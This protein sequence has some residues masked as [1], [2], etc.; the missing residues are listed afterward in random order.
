MTAAKD[1]AWAAWHAAEQQAK[2]EMSATHGRLRG[3]AKAAREAGAFFDDD[4]NYSP[5][6]AFVSAFS[7]TVTEYLV[8]ENGEW[9]TPAA[10]T[11]PSASKLFEWAFLIAK[12]E[13]TFWTIAGSRE[14]EANAR[15]EAIEKIFGLTHVSAGTRSALQ[16]AA[17][18]KLD[19]HYGD[20]GKWKASWTAGNRYPKFMAVTT[21]EEYLGS[22]IV[23]D[24][25]SLAPRSPTAEA[26]QAESPEDEEQ[27]LWP[28][29]Y[30]S[31]TSWR[32]RGRP[33]TGEIGKF[34]AANRFLAAMG[35]GA[36]SAAALEHTWVTRK[37]NGR[38]S[39]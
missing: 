8:D 38:D 9:P 24:I 2:E 26:G 23:H 14:A 22:C 10:A 4:V 36:A 5:F 11:V 12:T 15:Y 21:F 16:V 39:D 34:E 13:L 33:P 25:R 30:Q 7:E 31:A 1:E 3:A 27:A 32:R 37:K 29:A 35:L 6:V 18:S 17:L 20:V 19:R 28:L